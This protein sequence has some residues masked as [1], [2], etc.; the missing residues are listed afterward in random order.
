MPEFVPPTDIRYANVSKVTD[1]VYQFQNVSF[2]NGA[3][4][5]KT[6]VVG[7]EKSFP[8]LYY[9]PIQK[10]FWVPMTSEYLPDQV[11]VRW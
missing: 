7:S 3:L 9:Y 1:T 5:E 2:I 8:V 11:I 10:R 4:T 6:D